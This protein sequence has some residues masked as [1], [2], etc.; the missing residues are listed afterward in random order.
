MLDDILVRA[1]VEAGAELRAGF[2]VE[3]VKWDDNRV[4]GIRGRENDRSAVYE[5]ARI[6]VGADGMHST[7]AR[8][9][10]APEYNTKPPLQDPIFRTGAAYK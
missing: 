5:Q 7:V 1:A 4:V 10:H 6:V 3:E 9:V 2:S 8:A